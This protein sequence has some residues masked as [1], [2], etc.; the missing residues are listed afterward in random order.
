MPRFAG[1][2]S[3][4]PAHEAAAR[5]NRDIVDAPS[6]A[7]ILDAIVRDEVA[8]GARVDHRDTVTAVLVKGADRLLV[9]IDETGQVHVDRLVTRHARRRR[10]AWTAIAALTVIGV[11]L[12]AVAQ[13]GSLR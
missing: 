2:R 1:G 13:L 11:I 4:P 12:V 6:R 5:A 8:G 3:T 10:W 7:R 9:T